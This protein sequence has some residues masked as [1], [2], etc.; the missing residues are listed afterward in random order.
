MRAKLKC[1]LIFCSQRVPFLVSLLGICVCISPTVWIPAGDTKGLGFHQLILKVKWC[2]CIW[3]TDTVGQVCL[4]GQRQMILIQMIFNVSFIGMNKTWQ[5]HVSERKS[6]WNRRRERKVCAS[7]EL[8][9]DKREFGNANLN[10]WLHNMNSSLHSVCS[11]SPGGEQS[12]AVGS[13]TN[14][15]QTQLGVLTS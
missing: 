9:Y 4:S 2:S 6:D 13:E 15:A 7:P 14:W 10:D 12:K 8:A 1:F 3:I 5:V 11:I